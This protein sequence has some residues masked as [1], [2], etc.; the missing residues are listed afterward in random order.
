[1][2]SS[3]EAPSCFKRK[4][5]LKYKLLKSIVSNN[6]LDFRITMLFLLLIEIVNDHTD[7]EIE[8]EKRAEYDKEHEIEQHVQALLSSRL[9]IELNEHTSHFMI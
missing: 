6:M 5:S 4:S 3:A 8:R 2:K 7:E 9:L 1:M